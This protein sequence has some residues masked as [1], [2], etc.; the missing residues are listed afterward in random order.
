MLLML[1]GALTV[2]WLAVIAVVVALC[3][4]AARSD[5]VDARRPLS[6]R[7]RLRMIA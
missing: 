6:A 4:S 1:L 2:A 7:P 3:I 5:R